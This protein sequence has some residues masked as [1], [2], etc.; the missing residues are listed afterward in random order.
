[1]RSPGGTSGGAHRSPDLQRVRWV[2]TLD[3]GRREAVTI[4]VN[5]ILKGRAP[6]VALKDGN[7]LYVPTNH[8]PPISFLIHHSETSMRH[9]RQCL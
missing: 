6:Y 2:R 4:P 1:M 7:I 5:L 3:D 9:N 8:L